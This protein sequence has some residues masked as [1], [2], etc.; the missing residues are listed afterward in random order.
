MAVLISSSIPHQETTPAR[1]R[2]MNF[3]LIPSEKLPSLRLQRGLH[4]LLPWSQTEGQGDT[5]VTHGHWARRG[6]KGRCEVSGAGKPE[7]RLEQSCE[8]PELP[9]RLNQL[10]SRLAS[11]R[12]LELAGPGLAPAPIPKGWPG[13][14]EEEREGNQSLQKSSCPRGW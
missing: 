4:P 5:E 11:L 13:G 10:R 9:G 12:H 3:P 2:E 8:L 6:S 1:L 14:Q 7:P